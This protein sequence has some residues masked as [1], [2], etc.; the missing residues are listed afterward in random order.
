MNKMVKIT[1]VAFGNTVPRRILP[2]VVNNEILPCDI[3]NDISFAYI[4]LK[5]NKAVT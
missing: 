1:M 3:L 4:H 5:D 2:K